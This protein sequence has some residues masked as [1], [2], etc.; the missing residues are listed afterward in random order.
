MYIGPDL[1][2]NLGANG[3]GT[4]GA[5]GAPRGW[6]D[7]LGSHLPNIHTIALRFRRGRSDYQ[8][9]P[10]PAATMVLADVIAWKESPDREEKADFATWTGQQAHALANELWDMCVRYCQSAGPVLDFQLAAYSYDEKSGKLELVADAVGVRCNLTGEKSSMIDDPG[11]RKLE[12]LLQTIQA[13]NQALKDRDAMILKMMDRSATMLEKT[14]VLTE[15]AFKIAEKAFSMK[16]AVA[17]RVAEYD[18]KRWDFELR[19]EEIRAR[20]ASF[21]EALDRFPF[22]DLG[23]YWRMRAN[24]AD[25]P[26]N[27]RDAA[28][29]LLA[30][31]TAEQKAKLPADLVSDLE[32]CLEKAANQEDDE[33]AALILMALAPKL[34]EY[35]EEIGAVVTDYQRA[36][37]MFIRD[38]TSS[39][40]P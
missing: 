29:K 16:D 3:R 37:L 9:L 18:A 32:S 2:P 36:L 40:N 24:G 1:A 26:A 20:H 28:A 33:M 10:L 22:D 39:V 19:K 27:L 5:Q 34:L 12:P 13:Q 17:G 23:A 14:A 35:H 7:L 25:V 38:K 11:D 4:R 31:F 8:P 6:T 30:S 21:R 15:G